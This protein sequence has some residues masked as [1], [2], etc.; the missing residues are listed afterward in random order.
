M[1][2]FRRSSTLPIGLL[3]NWIGT[4][5]G[6]KYKDTG[7]LEKCFLLRNSRETSS[8]HRNLDL[9]LAMATFASFET[10]HEVGRQSWD[11]QCDIKRWNNVRKYFDYLRD[12][13]S[14][15][16]EVL[17][18]LCHPQVTKSETDSTLKCQCSEFLLHARYLRILFSVLPASA[19]ALHVVFVQPCVH[20]H[21]NSAWPLHNDHWPSVLPWIYLVQVPACVYMAPFKPRPTAALLN[22]QRGGNL[23][24]PRIKN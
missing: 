7:S 1:F 17:R 20:H 18:S 4:G 2:N 14:W 16:I 12:D 21:L 19:N 22:R 24:R 8:H 11:K 15:K 23:H 3:G 6:V 10:L 5:C 9:T 13:R